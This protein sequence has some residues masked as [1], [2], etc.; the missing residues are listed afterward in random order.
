[1]NKQNKKNVYINGFKFALISVFKS[2]IKQELE[3]DL[4]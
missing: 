2:R 1:M 3:D 4:S